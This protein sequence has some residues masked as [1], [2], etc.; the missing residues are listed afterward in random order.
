MAENL[1]IYDSQHHD[2]QSAHNYD[3]QEANPLPDGL[4]GIDRFLWSTYLSARSPLDGST[5][6]GAR[7]GLR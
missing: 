1:E 3:L 2:R 7:S 4:N 5:T 6:G